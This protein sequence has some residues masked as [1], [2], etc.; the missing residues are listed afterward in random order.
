MDR[1]EAKSHHQGGAQRWRWG[2][3][4]WGHDARPSMPQGQVQREQRMR[5][6]CGK[7]IR[8]ML[9]LSHAHGSSLKSLTIKITIGRKY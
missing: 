8:A 9:I 2:P 7:T 1:Q 4:R 6:V 5:N 3:Q